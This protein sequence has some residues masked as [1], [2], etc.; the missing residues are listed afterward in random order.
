MIEKSFSE[1]LFCKH[2]RKERRAYTQSNN[3]VV[4]A[5]QCQDCG[6]NTGHVKREGDPPP[7]DIEL[8]ERKRAE[9]QERAARYMEEM[10]KRLEE[11]RRFYRDEYLTSVVW[12]EKRTLVLRRC[13]YTC[14]GC[15]KEPATQVHHTEYPAEL[16]TE[17]LWVLRGVCRKC[18]EQ[19]HNI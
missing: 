10:E 8:R 6:Q 17:P 9:D 1:D 19:Q 16:G 15:G 12:K 14:E 11:R 2:N 3:V 13:N 7:F 18:H 4:H 5:M